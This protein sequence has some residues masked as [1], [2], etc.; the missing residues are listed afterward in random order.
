MGTTG[1]AAVRAARWLVTGLLTTGLACG[2]LPFERPVPLRNDL[3]GSAALAAAAL[4]GMVMEG[5]FPDEVLA[6][7]DEHA[8]RFTWLAARHDE[9]QVV[10]AALGGVAACAAEVD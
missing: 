7:C 6:A 4:A 10:A 5:T 8:A 9:P 1:G 2:G 3:E